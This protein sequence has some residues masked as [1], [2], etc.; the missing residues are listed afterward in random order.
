MISFG[1]PPLLYW[2]WIEVL[3]LWEQMRQ[4][5]AMG[6]FAKHVVACGDATCFAHSVEES[7]APQWATSNSIASLLANVSPFTLLALPFGLPSSRTDLYACLK[8]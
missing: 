4:K 8:D 6:S 7:V 2:D 3:A 5:G 1:V